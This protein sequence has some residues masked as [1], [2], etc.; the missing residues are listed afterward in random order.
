MIE[1][2]PE[3]PEIY[4]I[5]H[6]S[7]YLYASPVRHSTLSLY[8]K[9]RNDRLQRLLS[10][11]VITNPQAHLS[12]ETDFY[13]NTKQIMNIYREHQAL[14]ITSRSVVECSSPPPPPGFSGVGSWEEIL[15]WRGSYRYWEFTRP[16]AFA[17]PSPALSSFLKE[18]DVGPG[19]DPLQSLLQLSG[20]LF[21]RFQYVP[22][23]TSVLSPIE[24]ILETG[25]GVC[26]DYAHVMIAIARAWHIPTRYVSGYLYLDGSR[27]SRQLASHAW[28]ECL[29]PN[30]GWIGFDPTN[31]CTADK[32]YVR[33]AI[34]RDY[35]DVPPV[36][37]VLIGGGESRLDVSI[38]VRKA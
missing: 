31:N 8:L 19:D 11:D 24:H 1:S 15:S 6:V 29:L 12:S 10:Y 2:T 5:E 35:Q 33:V 18:L 36:R 25:Q 7:R 32:R 4:E 28:V 38:R 14:E 34:G 13:G 23:A 27:E 17:R 26:Q 16:S 30:V 21:R 22:G 37:G 3:I 20:T 9:P